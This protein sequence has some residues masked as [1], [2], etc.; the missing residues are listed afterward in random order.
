MTQLL[1]CENV[2]RLADD[3]IQFITNIGSPWL[4]EMGILK[5]LFHL[6]P[7]LCAIVPVVAILYNCWVACA[8]LYDSHSGFRDILEELI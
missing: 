1:V 6:S 7:G 3:V 4:M 2:S 8:A 5:T